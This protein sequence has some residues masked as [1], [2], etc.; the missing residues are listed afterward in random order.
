LVLQSF[1][2]A[3]PS[4]E[5]SGYNAFQP[6]VAVATI[7]NQYPPYSGY[8]PMLSYFDDSPGNGEAALK[9]AALDTGHVATVAAETPCT[10]SGCWGDY[11]EMAVQYDPT[12]SPQFVRAFTDSTA[13]ICNPRSD[14]DPDTLPMHVSVISQPIF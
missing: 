14:W 7:P 6:A 11:D 8:H 3:Q 5:C 2:P 4:A 12:A 1:L 9:F 13:S 10:F